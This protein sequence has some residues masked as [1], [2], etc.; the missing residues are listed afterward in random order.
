MRSQFKRVLTIFTIFQSDSQPA[1]SS[2]TNQ[3][4]P[5]SNLGLQIMSMGFL[6]DPSKAVAWRGPMVMGAVEKLLFG[7]EWANLDVLVVDMPPG[8]GDIHLSVA[9]TLQVSGMS[10]N[11]LLNCS[12]Y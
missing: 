10:S 2:T 8:T 5:L 3:M 12:V 1:V 9:Q 6:V 4:L 7:T 11:P